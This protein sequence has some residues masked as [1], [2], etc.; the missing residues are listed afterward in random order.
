[1]VTMMMMKTVVVVAATLCNNWFKIL[2][3]TDTQLH[4]VQYRNQTLF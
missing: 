1:V 3:V 2:Q 4:C